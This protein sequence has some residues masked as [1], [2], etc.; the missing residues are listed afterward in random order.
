MSLLFSILAACV[1]LA[2]VASVASLLFLLLSAAFV[3]RRRPLS[4]SASAPLALAVIVPAHNEELVLS[5]TLDSLLAQ[6]Y[7]AEQL[8]VV[9]VA[10]NCTDSTAALAR[11]RGATV[12]ER[13]HADERGKGYALNYAVSHLLSQ[14]VPPDGF[15]IVDADTW[16]SP[17]FL[18]VMNA[19]LQSES[20]SDGYGAWQGRYGVL[21]G[22]DGW[23]A[24]LMAAAFDLVNHVKP[25]GREAWK[26]SVGLKGNGMAFTRAVATEVPWPGDSLTEDLD[27]GLELARRF[28]VRVGYAPE[29]RVRA[30]MPTTAAQAG[31]QRS[32]WERGRFRMVRERALPLLGE[33]LRTRNRLLLD[34]GF[35]LLVPPLAELGALLVLWCGLVLLGLKL[36]LLPTPQIWLFAASASL[37]GL[38]VYILGGLRVAGAPPEAYAALLRAPFY[39]VWKFVLLLSGQGRR[40]GGAA[41]E[42]WVR[43]ERAPLSP[44]PKITEAP[45]Q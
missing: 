26:L 10:D 9:V 45:P 42:E 5:G 15:V 8:E 24:G 28:G 14:R 33:G 25:L 7:P 16:V 4:I 37:L 23:R 12:L 40:K 19:R 17:D 20:R 27:Y 6:N 11:A 31:S 13:T 32:R 18:A 30:Q 34:M 36:S 39:A 43:T 38:L 3:S 1:G 2:A 29:A 21:N 41:S 35:D 44:D 22:N